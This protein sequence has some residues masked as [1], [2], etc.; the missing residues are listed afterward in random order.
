MKKDHFYLKKG[1]VPPRIYNKRDVIR[2]YNNSGTAY[3][4]RSKFNSK[5]NSSFKINDQEQK[6]WLKD[7][8]ARISYIKTKHSF[9][10][11]ECWYIFEYLGYPIL[12][13][14]NIQFLLSKGII[15]PEQLDEHNIIYK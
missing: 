3:L 9:S 7:Q 4:D 12:C 13:T 10:Q 11:L 14:K 6:V 8:L 5:I 15:R 2:L 1:F